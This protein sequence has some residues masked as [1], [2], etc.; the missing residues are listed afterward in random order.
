MSDTVREH[1]L[2]GQFDTAAADWRRTTNEDGSPGK[3]EVGFAADGLVALRYAE[4]PDGTILIYTPAEWDAFV[5]GVKDGEFDIEVLE[6]DRREA[7]A[8]LD[9][10]GTDAA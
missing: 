5:A 9:A 6:A 1:P 3:L 2:K 8:Q 4:E 7:Q 10:D